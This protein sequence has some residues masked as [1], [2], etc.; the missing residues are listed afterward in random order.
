M[1]NSPDHAHHGEHAHEHGLDHP[2][3][4]RD[5]FGNPADLAAYLARLEGPE[6]TEWQKPD[7]VVRSLGLRPGQSVCEI[8]AGPGYFSLRLARAVGAEGTVFAVEVE[9]RILAVL[10]ERLS[11]AGTRNVVPVLGFPD[12][13]LVP[14]RSCDLVLAINAFHHIPD[15]TAFLRRLARTL[16]PGGRIV[17]ID[18]HKH[19]LPVG[20]PSDHKMAREDFLQHARAAGL[21]LAEELSLLPHQYFLVLRPR[22]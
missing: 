9:P 8:G 6:R 14:P 18:F 19:E 17:N 13:P 2:D 1:T 10:R 21:D 3:V 12:D 7:E 4:E 20:P 15:G 11:Q 22:G 5:R 16:K